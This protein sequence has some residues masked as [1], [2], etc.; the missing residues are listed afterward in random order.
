M[1]ACVN[2]QGRAGE[3]GSMFASVQ[4]SLLNAV[5]QAVGSSPLPRK[6]PVCSRPGQ[7]IAPQLQVLSEQLLPSAKPRS[8]HPRF[9]RA[10]HAPCLCSREHNCWP[11]AQ[12]KHGDKTQE[13]PLEGT[14]LC[15]AQAILEIAYAPQALQSCSFG[16]CPCC[17]PASHLHWL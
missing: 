3:G 8:S 1:Y 15:L 5:E 12:K 7:H 4:K 14:W 16:I 2:K 13:T 6:A 17:P 9:F 10:S 11:P